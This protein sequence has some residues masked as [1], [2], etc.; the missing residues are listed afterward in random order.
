MRTDGFKEARVKCATELEEKRAA[1]GDGA[2]PFDCSFEQ[3][4]AGESMR[5]GSGLR[6]VTHKPYDKY[7]EGF[8]E[9]VTTEFTVT[10]DVDNADG[11]F[12]YVFRPAGMPAE[13]NAFAGAL[14]VTV[15]P[16]KGKA[17]TVLDYASV[18]HASEPFEQRGSLSAEQGYFLR[19]LENQ[20]YLSTSVDVEGLKADRELRPQLD[21]LAPEVSAA[22]KA[23][24]DCKRKYFKQLA[25]WRKSS[26]TLV[27]AGWECAGSYTTPD[28]RVLNLHWSG[29][30]VE[31]EGIM[32]FDVT[33]DQP[34]DGQ[35]FTWNLGLKRGQ[36]FDMEA[37]DVSDGN[38]SWG[39]ETGTMH[40]DTFD[41]FAGPYVNGEKTPWAEGLI[42][43]FT[44]GGEKYGLIYSRFDAASYRAPA[45][46]TVK[47]VEGSRQDKVVL[48]LPDLHV[49]ERS[50]AQSNI[51]AQRV[52]D[53]QVEVLGDLSDK[54]G[55]YD[56]IL[57]NV[58]FDV[59]QESLVTQLT[60]MPPVQGTFRPSAQTFLSNNPRSVRVVGPVSSAEDRE[61]AL[62]LEELAD[63]EYTM[64]HPN[65]IR[66]GNSTE[67]T[68]G[69]AIAAAKKA[70]TSTDM[71]PE[72][73]ACFCNEVRW[74]GAEMDWFRNDRLVDDPKK[75]AAAAL[76]SPS[77]LSV[78]IA[79]KNHQAQIV[80]DLAAAHVPYLV[81][82][83]KGM[84]WGTDSYK[85]IPDPKGF[86]Q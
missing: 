69:S 26:G 57:E 55:P 25:T 41:N 81:V 66:C 8:G 39:Y 71:P 6:R 85:G 21:A 32:N 44:A 67:W 38:G 86:C 11:Q 51:E 46:A 2:L 83:P 12:H 28:Q 18:Y 65:E 36:I 58:P 75:E 54:Y 56:L 68:V 45:G 47:R 5:I 59:P 34:K 70:T 13:E 63:V 82:E 49:L 4:D 9:Y 20:V 62:H 80:K 29:N 77:R 74:T 24:D 23:A 40:T 14:R 50:S 7:G 42:A 84:A 60:Y 78:I 37:V 43:D 35:T 48:L 22:L 31:E 15:T 73:L 53:F 17:H 27:E 10:L 61:L 79:G 3:S 30:F 72:A 64:A 1:E 16:P 33:V 19:L 76:K 52:Q